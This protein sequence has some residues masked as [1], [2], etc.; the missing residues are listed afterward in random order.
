MWL[1]LRHQLLFCRLINKDLR[2]SILMIKKI[3]RSILILSSSIWVA[4]QAYAQTPEKLVVHLDKP[5]A[6]IQPTMWGIFFEDINFGADG[7]L[8]AEM[9]KNRSFEFND[10]LMGWDDKLVGGAEASILIVN[11]TSSTN[12]RYASISLKNGKGSYV[13]TNEGFR[14]MGFEKDHRYNFSIMAHDVDGNAKVNVEAVDES[15]KPV[16]RASLEDIEGDWKTYH[17]SFTA[18]ATAVKGKLN[19]IFEGQGKIE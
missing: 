2:V 12:P 17:V 1:C 3:A 15:G 14:G 19:L 5:G 8:Y 10:P 6:K 4:N 18:T 7:G 11:R 9:V 16:G 13:L